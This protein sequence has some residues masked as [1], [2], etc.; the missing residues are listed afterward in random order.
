MR[1]SVQ[2]TNGQQTLDL[3]W[4]EHKGTDIYSGPI[5]PN[6]NMKFSYHESG[7]FHAGFQ[8]RR[9]YEEVEDASE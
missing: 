3:Y 8:G 7:E 6:V 1:V 2:F 4:L 5:I 9:E